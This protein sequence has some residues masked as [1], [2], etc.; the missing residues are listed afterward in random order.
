[1]SPPFDYEPLGRVVFAP[2]ALNRLGELARSVGATRVLLVTDPGLETVGHPQRA[3]ESL[4]EAGLPV[5][6]FDGVQENPTE[7]HVARGVAFARQHGIDAIVAVGGGSAMDC[8][9]GVNFILTNGGRMADYKG[10]GK[11]T[12]PMLPSVGV[13]TTS[14]TGSEAQS[15]ALITDESSHL[16]MA[17]GDKKAAFRVAILDPELTLTQPRMVTA[18]TGI[19]AVAHA[20]EAFVCTRRN[21]VSAASAAAAWR[22][23]APNF[24]AVLHAPGDLAARSA[25]QLGAYL[26]GSAIEHSM[27]GACHSCANPLTAHYGLTHGVA[28]GIVLPH[29]VRFNAVAVAHLYAELLP[30][31]DAPGEELA[32]RV[33]AMVETAGL[34]TRLRDLGVSEGILPLLAEEANQ[35][36]TA[37]FNPRPV[38][39]ADLLAIYQAAY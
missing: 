7:H 15:Y 25:M 12:K 34:P 10:H 4:T 31:S 16:K 9:K 5:F 23:L 26:A 22:H 24:E 14:G 8:A 37:R 39:D 1:M 2:G 36:W 6:T 17:C 29:V 28:I 11:A 33:A 30:G 32:R 27:L 35:Q 18:V 3:A 21:A 38:T 13:P 19:D 20:L